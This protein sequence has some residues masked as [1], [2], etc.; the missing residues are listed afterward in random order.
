[1]RLSAASGLHGEVGGAGHGARS[2]SFDRVVEE[3]KY[4]LE[5][6]GTQGLKPERLD[7]RHVEGESELERGRGGS[8]KRKHHVP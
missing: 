1:M 2:A 6:C 3:L 4:L 8:R 7:I 5:D